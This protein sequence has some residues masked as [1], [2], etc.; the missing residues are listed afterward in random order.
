[1]QPKWTKQCQTSTNWPLKEGP[2]TS[3]SKQQLSAPNSPSSRPQPESSNI[4]PKL[5]PLL[6]VYMVVHKENKSIEQS[7][8]TT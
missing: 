6:L 1:M 5:F 2:L 4:S 3:T 7:L 8:K